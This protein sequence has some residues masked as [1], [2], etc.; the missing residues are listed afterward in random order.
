VESGGPAEQALRTQTLQ[1][2]AGTDG[3]TVLAPVT[4]RGEVIGLL[5]MVLSHEPAAGVLREITRTAHALA[6]VV[7]T[8]RRHTDLFEWGQRRAPFSLSAEIQRRLLQLR[9]R[10][11]VQVTANFHHRAASARPGLHQQVH[12]DLPPD[13]M[14]GPTLGGR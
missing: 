8:N 14:L 9:R 5:E 3:W 10:C 12:E 1:V 13:R 7:I 4:D 2:L 6:F 11:H